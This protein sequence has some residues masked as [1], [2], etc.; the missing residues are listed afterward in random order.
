MEL[1]LLSIF[2]I[3]C[4]LALELCGLFYKQLVREPYLAGSEE[5]EHA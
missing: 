4:L 5:N 1:I 2:G 3:G